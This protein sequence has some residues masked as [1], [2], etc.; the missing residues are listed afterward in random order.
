MV[1]LKSTRDEAQF[2]SIGST[3]IMPSTSNTTNG[4]TSFRQ[5]QRFPETPVPSLE[6]HQVQG[7]N[8]RKAL[9]TPYRLEMRV[10]SLASTEE[11][12]QLS[13]STT[14]GGFPLE[15]V[16]EKGPE[17]ATSRGVETERPWLER[18]PDFP[19]VASMQ[20]C[21]SSHKMKDYL[22]PLWRP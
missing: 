18:R 15:Y 22:N 2:P 12:C 1:Y 3:A 7:N 14:R 17:F 11:V 6:E 8:S 19:S 13:T 16:C 4:L 20:A 21:L 5:L 10:D 9:C